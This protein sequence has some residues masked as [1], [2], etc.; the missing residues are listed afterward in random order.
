MTTMERPDGDI[1]VFGYGSLMWRPNFPHSETRPALLRGYHRALCIYSVEYRGT[2]ETPGL[3]FGLDRGG[4]CKGMAFK[5]NEND[6]EDV[7]NYLY[8]R[9]MVTGVYR[10]RW[11]N[12]ELDVGQAKQTVLSYLFVAD[13]DHPQYTGKLED[14]AA[15]KIVL[16]GHGKAGP[17]IDY[18]TNT[19]DHLI[20]LGIHDR[21]LERIIQKTKAAFNRT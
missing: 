2:Y 6:A 20:E 12:I 16:Q 17:C 14:D 8:E 1:W 9:E 19:F 11:Q 5:V 3:V 15:V 7:M 18:L 21:P 4:S 10:P 13:P